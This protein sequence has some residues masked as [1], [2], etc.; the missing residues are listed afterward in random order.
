[1]PTMSRAAPTPIAA[2]APAGGRPQG[3]SH[4]SRQ[5]RQLRWEGERGDRGGSARPQ[6]EG[7]A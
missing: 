7:G 4:R 6:G 3:M 1:M 2:S 5:R